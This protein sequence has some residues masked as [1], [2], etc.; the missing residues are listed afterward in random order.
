MQL[1]S[2]QG[3]EKLNKINQIN[4]QQREFEGTD[5]DRRL[6]LGGGGMP[7]SKRRAPSSTN[8]HH[9]HAST[10]MSPSAHE[11]GMP[12]HPSKRLRHTSGYL[13][14]SLLICHWLFDLFYFF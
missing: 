10:E 11:D 6:V 2:N 1:T 7:R 14:I 5:R 13:L 4:E 8:Y 12:R 3:F 9:H